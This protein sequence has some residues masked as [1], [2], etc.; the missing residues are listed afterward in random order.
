MGRSFLDF[1][2]FLKFFKLYTRRV[3]A[4]V[5]PE[6]E[7]QEG[8]WKECPQRGRPKKGCGKSAPREEDPSRVVERMPPE[9]ETKEGL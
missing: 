5:P 8:L 6:R 4:R 7:T 2:K 1:L 3:V 9:R